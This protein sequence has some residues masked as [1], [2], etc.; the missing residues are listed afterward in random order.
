MLT[1]I[2]HNAYFHSCMVL[3]YSPYMFNSPNPS[4]HIFNSPNPSPHIFNSPNTSPHIFQFSKSIRL[5]SI[6]C[7]AFIFLSVSFVISEY[8]YDAYVLSNIEFHHALNPFSSKAPVGT[9]SQFQLHIQALG[10]RR[11]ERRRGRACYNN[12]K[13]FSSKIDHNFK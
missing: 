6:R 1:P 7:S 9:S 10:R 8:N 3:I 2:W 5:W 12:N 13:R 11:F 4:R